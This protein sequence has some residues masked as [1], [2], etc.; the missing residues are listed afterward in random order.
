[1]FPTALRRPRYWWLIGLLFVLLSGLIEL[2]QPLANR[3][4]EAAD[5]LANSIGILCGVLLARMIH[6]LCGKPVSA[7]SNLSP[8]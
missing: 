7:S 2:I 3:H 1:M 5:L 8:K 4:M 6:P